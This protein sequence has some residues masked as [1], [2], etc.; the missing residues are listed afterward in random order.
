MSP[1]RI[2]AIDPGE[3]VGWAHGDLGWE[4]PA[5][6][7]QGLP[8]VLVITGHGITP[9]KDFAVKL[10]EVFGDYDVVVYETFRLYPHMARKLV[11]N[12][13]QTAQLVGMIRLCSWLNPATKLVS[14]GATIKKTAEKRIPNELPQVQVILDRMPKSH[15]DAHD[16]DALLHLGYHVLTSKIGGPM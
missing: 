13:M 3:K 16:G 8:P 12:D 5:D 6:Y 1:S 15:D 11:G 4:H 2:L 7:D 14:Q 9:L 10:S